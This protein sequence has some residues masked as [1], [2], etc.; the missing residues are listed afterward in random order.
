MI[1]IINC[2]FFYF[3]ENKTN[4]M[5]KIILLLAICML[6]TNIFAEDQNTTLPFSAMKAKEISIDISLELPIYFS[7]YTETDEFT[8]KTPI[9]E[10]QNTQQANVSAF[11]FDNNGTK[12]L[13]EIVSENGNNYAIFKIKP[14]KR[15]EY[16]FY[17]SGEI[18]SRNNFISNNYSTENLEEYTKST[19]YIKSDSSEIRTIANNLRIS[20]DDLENLV[21]VNNWVHSYLEYDLAFIPLINDSLKTLSERKGV[22][23]E[24][25]VLVAAILRAQGHPVRYVVGYANTSQEWGAHAWLEVYLKDYG[26]ISVDP[27][28]NEVG[29]VDA[30]HIVLEKLKDPHDSKDSVVSTSNVNI[31]FGNK[32]HAIKNK[33]VSSFEEKS[34]IPIIMKIE[35]AKDSTQNSPYIAKLE[36]KNT[37]SKPAI[38]L[39]VSQ[40]SKDFTQLYPK[41]KKNVYYLKPYETKTVDYYFKLPKL[42]SSYVYEFGFSSQYTDVFEKINIYHNR[43][44]PQELFL[45]YPPIIYYKNNQLVFESNIINYT[46]SNKNISFIFD[47]N[48]TEYSD[49][50][51]ISSNTEILYTRTFSNQEGAHLNYSIIGDYSYSRQ[52]SILETIQRQEII[53]SNTKQLTTEEKDINELFDRVYEN[54]VIEKPKT[55]YVVVVGVCLFFVFI[56]VLFIS[57]LTR[58]NQ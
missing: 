5:R 15:N 8:Y 47:Y 38:V 29:L 13:G 48:G 9:F 1:N 27:T 23:D 28:Y 19:T 40:L 37:T 35:S 30:T 31:S 32:T 44:T 51:I 49:N 39:I 50:K 2:C 54:R 26:W 53:D 46:K 55:N 16:I 45:S 41:S 58:K 24:F 14:I 11:Y 4:T 21:Y 33:S 56:I 25:S 43:G 52:L 34:D 3:I 17:I 36:I 20:D 7:N 12:V 6:L 10:N 18:V 42:T 57:K 22:C